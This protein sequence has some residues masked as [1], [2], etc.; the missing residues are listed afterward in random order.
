MRVISGTDVTGLSPPSWLS[1]VD[2]HDPAHRSAACPL[3]AGEQLGTTHPPTRAALAGASAPVGRG[4]LPSHSKTRPLDQGLDFWRG[5][6]AVWAQTLRRRFG[7]AACTMCDFGPAGRLSF[8]GFTSRWTIA[9][10]AFDLAVTIAGFRSSLAGAGVGAPFPHER[11]PGQR[12]RLPFPR[13]A[14]RNRP[15]KPHNTARG[16]HAAR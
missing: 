3:D 12:D 4:A 8:P 5:L 2:Q 15:Q 1:P 13:R 16:R 14:A 7:F 10:A 6:L 11:R 9:D